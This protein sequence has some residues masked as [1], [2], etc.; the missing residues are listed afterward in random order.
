M[1]KC[2]CN[3]CG[4]EFDEF[5]WQNS[6]GVHQAVMY[7]SQFDGFAINLDLCCECFDKLMEDYILPRAAH[8]PVEEDGGSGFGF[9]TVEV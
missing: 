6:F 4:K 3:I 8:N 5:D 1:R 9:L 2:M 7:G